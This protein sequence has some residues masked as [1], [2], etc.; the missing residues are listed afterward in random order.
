MKNLQNS[1][2]SDFINISHYNKISR[3][4]N[5]VRFRYFTRDEFNLW[6]NNLNMDMRDNL[7]HEYI[8]CGVIETCKLNESIRRFRFSIE[9][10]YHNKRGGGEDD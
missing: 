1:N 4:S 5:L 3:K 8:D 9:F 10:L 7:L 6:F 2:N